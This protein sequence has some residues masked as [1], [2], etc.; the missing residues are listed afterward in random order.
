[1]ADGSYDLRAT[2]TDAAGYSTT[3]A[4]VRTTVANSVLVVLTS[5]GKVVRG[6]V[7]LT[8]SLHNGG[9]STYTVR[10]QYSLAGANVWKDICTNL[11]SPYS[12]SWVTTEYTND[13]Y[14]LRSVAF[15]G[16]STYV[17]A[18]VVDVLVDNLAPNLRSAASYS[19]LGSAVA[20]GGISSLSGDLGAYPTV[21]ATGFPTGTVQ[22]ETHTGDAI[23]AQA[24]TDLSTAYA[25]A[26]SRAADTFFAGDQIGATFYPGVHRTGAAFA[27]SA[28][29]VV[30]LDAQGDPNAVFIFQIYGAL[31]T[32]A[33]SRIVLV[34]SATA[35]NVFWAS[36]GAVG[37]GANSSFS[38]TILTTGAVTIGAGGDLI[39]RALAEGA[40]TLASNTV[41][42]TVALAPTITI[43]GGS[44]S[45]TTNTTPLLSG[46]STALAGRTV[47]VSISGQTLS[48]TVLTDHSWSV[49][50]APLAA[51]THT[52]FV[53]VRDADGNAATATA[54]RTVQ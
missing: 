11:A 23:A 40:V 52:V 42:F 48:A 4:T 31:N 15:S 29:G 45:M 7:P 3:S 16:R 39:G 22:G 6:T 36:T 27:L 47:A 5:P 32:A 44:S 54:S 18:M 14:D 8:T 9:T 19:V 43:D 1:M 51:G 35:S 46:T 53:R 17:S 28:N 34:N 49:T 20:N 24:K 21:A 12:C 37:T 41:R 10:V 13:Y 38:G 33:D 30:T 26:Q 50:A 25:D 2:A